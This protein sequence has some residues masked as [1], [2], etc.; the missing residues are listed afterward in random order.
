MTYRDPA[1]YER[2]RRAIRNYLSDGDWHASREI[3]ERLANDV[4]K[5]WLFGAIKK[6]L[7]IERRQMKR[8]LL[9]ASGTASDREQT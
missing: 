2:A 4:P 1:Q 9:L 5:D 6:E 7:L 8:A 3:H